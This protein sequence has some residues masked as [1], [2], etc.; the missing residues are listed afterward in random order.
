MIY[1]YRLKISKL[2]RQSPILNRQS[3]WGPIMLVEKKELDIE[4]LLKKAQNLLNLL[5]ELA[6]I[7]VFLS[8]K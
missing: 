6:L 8:N 5:S 3:K 7:Q 1:D 4:E 2:N